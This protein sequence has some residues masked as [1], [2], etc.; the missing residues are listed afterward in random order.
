MKKYLTICLALFSLLT[1]SAK[2]GGPENGSLTISLKNQPIT[3]V[4]IK[5]NISQLMGEPTVQGVYRWHST[6]IKTIES[7]AVLWLE[8]SSSDGRNRGYIQVSP[9]VPEEGEWGMDTTGSPNWDEVIVQSFSKGKADKYW[10]AH[11]AKLFWK[12]GFS[13]TGAILNYSYDRKK[14][15]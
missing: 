7:N 14:S 9:T 4:D 11:D 10:S 15:P 12:A 6:T 3:S 1:A 2:A 13:V 8:V 5:Y